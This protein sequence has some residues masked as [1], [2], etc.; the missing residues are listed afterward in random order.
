MIPWNEWL[1]AA[2]I[3]SKHVTTCMKAE[4]LSQFSNFHFSLWTQVLYSL[5][6]PPRSPCPCIINLYLR[7]YSRKLAQIVHLVFFTSCLTKANLLARNSVSEKKMFK[8]TF[9]MLSTDTS[10]FYISEEQLTI[11]KNKGFC[12]LEVSPTKISCYFVIVWW[13]K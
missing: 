3:S 1:D 12:D 6:S 10:A 11:L 7:C 13:R 5:L 2:F 9:I 8:W 4:I